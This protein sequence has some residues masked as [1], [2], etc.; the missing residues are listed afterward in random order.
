V[1]AAGG[2]PDQYAA[3]TIYITDLQ[4]YLNNKKSLGAA[5]RD[6]FGKC[7]PAITL[8]QVASLQSGLYD[9]DLRCRRG[10]LRNAIP[11]FQ[12]YDPFPAYSVINLRQT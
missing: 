11:Y 5:Y 10:R 4:A 1:E 2:R 9:R 8:V 12:A 7:F 6:V 3:L